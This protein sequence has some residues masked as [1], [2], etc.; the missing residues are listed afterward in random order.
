MYLISKLLQNSLAGRFGMNN[1]QSSHTI[2][3]DNE[4][5]KL[6]SNDK[7]K[8]KILDLENGSSLI[9]LVNNNN[10]LDDNTNLDISIPI[11]AAI[12]S[13]ARIHM[14]NLIYD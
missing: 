4:I 8:Y 14:I 12:T 10:L 7:F 2:V 11:A 6:T 9:T 1:E 5:D 3:K 13:Y